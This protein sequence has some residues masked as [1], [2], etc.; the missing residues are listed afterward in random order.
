MTAFK[1]VDMFARNV[2]FHLKSNLPPD[3]DAASKALTAAH[4][5]AEA[6]QLYSRAEAVWV[7]A[8]R[9]GDYELQNEAAK[10]RLFAQRRTGELLAQMAPHPDTRGQGRPR[11][12]GAKVG[13][14]NGATAYPV[15]L[16]EIGVTGVTKDH[17]SKWQQVARWMS[18]LSSENRVGAMLYRALHSSSPRPLSNHP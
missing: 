16:E 18:A 4:R 10:I 17:P 13:R 1:E 15:T 12:D 6:K 9:S 11:R 5:V 8:Q 2:S 3:Q 14:S 7:Y